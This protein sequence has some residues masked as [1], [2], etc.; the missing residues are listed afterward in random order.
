MFNKPRLF[1]HKLIILCTEL[2]LDD[3]V[4]DEFLKGVQFPKWLHLAGSANCMGTRDFG[5]YKAKCLP[6]DKPQTCNADV[7]IQL[8]NALEKGEIKPCEEKGSFS[9]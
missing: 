8:S 1:E 3:E 6:I 4:P 2:Y 5:T 9:F 7:W